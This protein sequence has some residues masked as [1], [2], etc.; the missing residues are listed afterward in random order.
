MDWRTCATSDRE[1]AGESAVYALRNLDMSVVG[2]R[3]GDAG[4]QDGAQE[5]QG[6]ERQVAGEK[7]GESSGCVGSAQS[8]RMAL[9]S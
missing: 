5:V 4:V 7:P 2:G 8:W 6:K 3:V 9:C 1:E